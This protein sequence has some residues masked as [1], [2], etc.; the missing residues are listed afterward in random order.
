[1]SGVNKSGK[2]VNYFDN[3]GFQWVFDLSQLATGIV[4]NI[5]MLRNM[6]I[7]S[8]ISSE[9]ISDEEEKERRKKLLII[10]YL[11]LACYITLYLSLFAVQFKLY[12]NPDN[13]VALGF[14]IT[15]NLLKLIL[16]TCLGVTT[17]I[18][19]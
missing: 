6:S 4:C 19:S 1:M 3:D 7:A 5:F 9:W 11:F 14:Y 17:I 2:C 18:L 8:M 16:C 13:N 12:N 10:T 15:L